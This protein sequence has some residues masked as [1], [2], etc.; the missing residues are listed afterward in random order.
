[1]TTGIKKIFAAMLSITMLANSNILL[2]SADNETGQSTS[3][4]SLQPLDVDSKEIFTS[5]EAD[6]DFSCPHLTNNYSENE[7]E[8]IILDLKDYQRS[9][10]KRNSNS[11]ET[12]TYDEGSCGNNAAYTF[13]NGILTISGKGAIDNYKDYFDAPWA[14]YSNNINTLEI[15]NGITEIGAL[16][17]Y[18][19]HNLETIRTFEKTSDNNKKYVGN[20]NELTSNCKNIGFAAFGYCTS[21]KS[22]SISCEKISNQAFF[23]CRGLET[24]VLN[25]SVKEIEYGIFSYCSKIE[26]ITIPSSIE[27]IHNDAFVNMNSLAYITVDKGNSNYSNDEN[28]ILYNKKNNK[29]I[30]IPTLSNWMNNDTDSKYTDFSDNNY[31]VVN[32]CI[33]DFVPDEYSNGTFI[34]NNLTN[35][36][37]KKA[38]IKAV[39]LIE[40][41]EY[42]DILNITLGRDIELY[43]KTFDKTKWYKTNKNN[44]MVI[45]ESLS[46][47]SSTYSRLY[48][49][50]STSNDVNISYYDVVEGNAFE[51]KKD[52]NIIIDSNNAPKIDHKAF[53]DAAISSISVDGKELSYSDFTFDKDEIILTY[54][55]VGTGAFTN[56]AGIFKDEES[57]KAQLTL[58]I[59]KSSPTMSIYEK[60]FCKDLIKKMGWKELAEKDPYEAVYAIQKWI[61]SNSYYTGWLAKS[62]YFDKVVYSFDNENYID[63][64]DMS[65]HTFGNIATGY[66]V[67][68]GYSST[69]QDIINNLEV[70]TLKSIGLGSPTHAFAMIGVNEKASQSDK[71][72]I[73]YYTEPQGEAYLKGQKNFGAGRESYYGYRK[74]DLHLGK[75]KETLEKNN[76]YYSYVNEN[77]ETIIVNDNNESGV[78][79][80][81]DYNFPNKNN[82]NVVIHKVISNPDHNVN[83]SLSLPENIS[84]CEYRTKE[85]SQGYKLYTDAENKLD[86]FSVI[87]NPCNYKHYKN[88]INFK[89]ILKHPNIVYGNVYKVTDDYNL[90][91]YGIFNGHTVTFTISDEDQLQL[92]K[93]IYYRINDYAGIGNIAIRANNWGEFYNYSRNNN[94][95]MTDYKEIIKYTDFSGY[96]SL[97]GVDVFDFDDPDVGTYYGTT[98]VTE[99]GEKKNVGYYITVTKDPETKEKYIDIKT[100]QAGDLN[101]NGSIDAEDLITLRKYLVNRYQF[102]QTGSDGNLTFNAN[103]ITVNGDI[104]AN[105]T[106]NI[107]GGVAHVNGTLTARHLNDAVGGSNLNYKKVDEDE[108]AFP[109]DIITNT[110][111]DENMTEWYF[112]NEDMK[113]Y[114]FTKQTNPDTK[115]HGKDLYPNRDMEEIKDT[116]SKNGYLKFHGGFNVTGNVKATYDISVDN[117]EQ[118]KTSSVI[119][120]E[121]GDISI[122]SDKVTINGFIY[123]PNGKVTITSDDL[124]I[125]GTIIAK[126]LEIVSKGNLNFNVAFLDVIGVAQLSEFQ[127]MLADLNGDGRIDVF[128]SIILQRKYIN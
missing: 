54:E 5:P 13:S 36:K 15:S 59:L 9:K 97:A 27:N 78:L 48:R 65:A 56:G 85:I 111:S 101:L 11:S 120:S 28:G 81:T 77:G 7:T 45:Y 55:R 113:V 84:T 94:T 49:Y 110:F 25:K 125:T 93:K 74:K 98:P 4:I 121:K 107:L 109:T 106:M 128:D 14:S 19:L 50:N 6:N 1:M 115:I 58:A 62:G 116:Y 47:T 46:P 126:E 43:P 86:S 123:A 92:N 105:G 96:V 124:N 66:I 70:N 89:D 95:N 20:I 73:W 57:L 104:A 33:Y 67:C 32:N 8:E 87:I 24:I 51:N 37:G 22:I 99:F 35:S 100:Y 17:F 90:Y 127:L 88:Y 44:T 39:R 119:Y 23:G 103:N 52:I 69:L 91:L 112:S 122:T 83:V 117:A 75:I 21:L 60:S 3:S 34:T 12:I 64:L 79:S 38:D 10:A 18:N 29:L 102:I 108:E 80:E 42:N 53:V 71:D 68:G 41:K 118:F 31:L 2:I 114:D 40:N 76:I 82:I 72:M 16:A 63:Y 30:C 61:T 26:N